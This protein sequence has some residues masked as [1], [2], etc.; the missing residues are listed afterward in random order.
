M[1]KY[2]LILIL[3]TLSS[4]SFAFEKIAVVDLFKVIPKH[5]DYDKSKSHLEKL[6]KKNE[7]KLRKKEEKYVNNLQLFSKQ[8]SILSEKAISNREEELVK[9][10]QSLLEY[11]NQ[12]EEEISK[13]DNNYKSKILSDIEEKLKQYNKEKQYD[14]IIDKKNNP[15]IVMKKYKDITEDFIDF[16]Q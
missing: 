16:I 10:H 7:D 6:M 4:Y 5:K 15:F 14:L 8:K 11:K 1:K 3:S 13:E 2:I 9:E 12:L